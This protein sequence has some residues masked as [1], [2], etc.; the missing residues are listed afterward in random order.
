MEI[1]NKV[2]AFVGI[3]G[4]MAVAVV[5]LVTITNAQSSGLE[6]LEAAYKFQK[7]GIEKQIEAFCKTEQSIA[8]YKVK[9]QIDGEAKYDNYE[10]LTKKAI[11]DGLQCRQLFISAQNQ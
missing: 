7:E 1:K 8:Q 5:A 2:Q 3:M 11:G 4:T 10:Q 9:A 6:S